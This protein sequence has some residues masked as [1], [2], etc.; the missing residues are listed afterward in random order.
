MIARGFAMKLS[1]KKLLRRGNESLAIG[2]LFSISSIGCPCPVCFGGA[3]FGYL[4]CIKEK[5]F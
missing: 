5:F 1:K 4:N 2:I 3:L